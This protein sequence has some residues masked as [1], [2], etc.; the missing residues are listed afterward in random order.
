MGQLKDQAHSHAAIYVKL[1]LTAVFW[2]G[3][4]I[5]GSHV[6]K[7]L[8][9]FTIAFL[10]FVTASAILLMLAW[11][12]EGRLPRLTRGQFV[13]IALLGA[14]G[15]F[16]YN[17]LFFMGLRLIEAGRASLIVSMSPVLIA[18]ASALFL[19]DGSGKLLAH[20]LRATGIL[21]SV[22]GA[23][24][25]ISQGDLRRIF[26]GGVGLGELF[27]LGCVL[28]WVVYSVVGKVAMRHLS[29]LTAVAYSSAIGALALAVP[30]VM[31]GPAKNL[32][33]ASWIDWVSIAYLAVFGT[34][35]G[36]VWFYEGV[37]LIGA[38]RAGLFI[39]F[40]PVSAVILAAVILHEPITWSLAVGAA[41]V[42]SGVFL[43][44]RTP[45]TQ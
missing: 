24:V 20:P 35:L 40:V 1:V 44:N 18:V 42:L 5:A 19:R 6:S 30:A 10:R 31:E 43:T 12:Q 26:T 37:R 33:G 4:F 27:S 41:M 16:A 25:V 29:P 2:G 39:N 13:L 45:K 28:S 36:F 38:P 7:H 8:A 23:V 3:T 21:L 17:A 15:V 9:P 34:V 11:S 14:T 32:G 22:F